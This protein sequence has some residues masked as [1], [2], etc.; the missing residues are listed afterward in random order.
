MSSSCRLVVG[1]YW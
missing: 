1:V